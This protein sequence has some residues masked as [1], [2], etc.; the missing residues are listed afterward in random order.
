MN[1]RL[2]IERESTQATRLA[3]IFRSDW[4]KAYPLT[5][6][7]IG[8]Y[9]QRAK[10]PRAST[11]S[12][13]NL[14]EILGGETDH[15]SATVD[16]HAPRYWCDGIHQ[17]LKKSTIALI[18][19][20]T[21]WEQKGYDWSGL[22]TNVYEDDDRVLL[23]DRRYKPARL[24]I[25]RIRAQT[26]VTTSD[27]RYFVAHTPAPKTRTRKLTK[28]FRKRLVVIGIKR[29][30]YIRQKLSEKRWRAVAELFRK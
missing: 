13:S 15:F 21:G 25:M 16:D 22:G 2:A 1:I 4:N 11:L 24:H 23:V 10:R 6:A 30:G 20:Q 19:E 3:K 18:E 27:G 12:A 9:E 29:P 8:R 14:K 5:A 17:T 7:R 26:E 28:N